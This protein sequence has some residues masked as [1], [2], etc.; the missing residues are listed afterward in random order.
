MVPVVSKFLDQ[1]TDIKYTK[2]D[3]DKFPDLKDAYNVKGVPTFIAVDGEEVMG[4][5]VGAVPVAKLEGIFG[6]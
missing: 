4:R 1:N 5:V 3:I 6:R 2:I